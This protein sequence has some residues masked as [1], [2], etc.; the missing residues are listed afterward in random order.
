MLRSGDIFAASS[1]AKDS[2]PGGDQ[3]SSSNSTERPRI[4]D[5]VSDQHGGHW[6][7]YGIMKR[8]VWF[9]LQELQTNEKEV[10]SRLSGPGM[11]FLT[12]KR[13]NAFKEE[14]EAHTTYR[15]ALVAAHPGWLEGHFILGDGTVAAPP[16]D[17][18]EV[19]IAF[20]ANSKFTLKGNLKEY[21][22]SV[23]SIIARQP[24]GL[25]AFAY[26]MAP[27]ILRYA[28]P[29]YINPQAELVG[30]PGSG[31]STL[32]LFAASVWAGDPTSD[33]GGAES[34][35]VTTGYIDRQKVAHCDM[36]L[37]RDEANLA[38]ITLQD[39]RHMTRRAIFQTAAKGGRKRLTDTVAVPNF[40]V[41][42]LSTSNIPM[43]EVVHERGALGGALGSRMVTIQIPK[44]NPFGVLAFLPEGIPSS[45]K[46][47]EHLRRAIDENYGCA[48]RKFVAHLVR[49]AAKDRAGLCRRIERLTSRF[50]GQLD[51]DA[52]QG[53]KARVAK[54]FA[55]AYAA[56]MLA[57]KWGILPKAWGPLLSAILQVYRSVTPPQ[58]TAPSPIPAINKIRA[59][60]ERHKA[61]LVRMRNVQEP[62]SQKAFQTAAGFLRKT[63]SCEEILIP[64][65]QFQR[66]FPD[67]ALL[68]KELRDAWLAK[69]EGGKQ[70][71]LSVKAPKR[72]CPTGRVYCITLPK[73]DKGEKG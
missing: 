73:P 29:D 10:F 57:R 53:G 28:P 12:T 27:A 54:T 69:T 55:I 7:R 26:A 24:L 22:R 65:E 9:S 63:N 39:Q 3:L 67:H 61:K 50:L 18:R 30:E 40:N 38:G 68:M 4:L 48:G 20:D 62:Y 15:S 42:L 60:V 37:V 32:A 6:I 25:W 17:L 13:R 44:E 14:V 5:A 35:D 49:A 34:W 19:I 66:M 16:D 31:K 45:R 41:G 70:A 1:E 33:V 56:G 2:A 52:I 71:K 58:A 64:T 23:G 8:S 43:R 11:T 72:L 59:Y 21:Q 51:E 46:A 47:I 36:L